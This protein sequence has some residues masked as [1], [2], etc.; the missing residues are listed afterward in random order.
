RRRDV[1]HREE[2]AEV[3]KAAP[4]VARLEQH[5]DRKAPD[6]EQRSEVFQSPLRENLAL[7]AQVGGEEDDQQN[8]RKLAG[9]ELQRAETDP[10]SC[11]V[12][13][14]AEPGRERQQEQH[15]RA[16]PEDVLVGLE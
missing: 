13:G 6:Q 1:Q 14:P 4:K 3:E 5:Q 2:D 8:L 16:Q 9:L 15:D 11:A 12:D 10:Q 7:L